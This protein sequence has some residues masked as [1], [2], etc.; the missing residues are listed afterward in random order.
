MER[1]IV[2]EFKFHPRND[3]KQGQSESI[4]VETYIIDFEPMITDTQVQILQGLVEDT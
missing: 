1:Q 4:Q 3:S 2:N